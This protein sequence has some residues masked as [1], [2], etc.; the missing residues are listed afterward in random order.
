MKYIYGFLAILA[1]FGGFVMLVIAK[2]AIH[3]IEAFIMFL[4]AAVL[5]VAAE[6]SEGFNNLAKLLTP[7]EPEIAQEPGVTSRMIEGL[8]HKQT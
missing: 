7:K 1:I 5:F 6:A 8:K 2:S 3:E 4:I